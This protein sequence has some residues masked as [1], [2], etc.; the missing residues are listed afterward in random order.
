MVRNLDTHPV[1]KCPSCH[2]DLPFDR[3]YGFHAGHADLGFLYDETGLHVFVWS[4][5][6]PDYVALVGDKNP[7]TLDLQ[8]QGL[9]ESRLLPAPSGK[10]WAFSN[11]A[12]CPMCQRPISDPMMKTRMGLA[13]DG[14]NG[15]GDSPPDFVV[16]FRKYLSEGAFGGVCNRE[17][18]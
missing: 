16:P 9:V 4:C 2:A 17:H 6:D 10:R 18:G 3:S 11:P 13:F 15:P 1:K 5:L 7:W 12:R 14:S 8:E